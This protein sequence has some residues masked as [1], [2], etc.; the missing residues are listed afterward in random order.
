MFS[1][2]PIFQHRAKQE[3]VTEGDNYFRAYVLL[4]WDEGKAHQRA[5]QKIKANKEIYDAVK[6]SD[7]IQEMEDKVEAYR[8][9]H[10]MND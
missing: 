4:E 3:V 2:A 9:R 7:M 10:G 5:L 8:Q 1:N 6:A